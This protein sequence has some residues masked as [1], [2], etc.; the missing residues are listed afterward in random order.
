MSATQKVITQEGVL[1]IQE[2]V[3]STQ[4]GVPSTQEGVPSTQDKSWKKLL[5]KNGSGKSLVQQSNVAENK[6]APVVEDKIKESG[7]NETSP[8]E[9]TAIKSSNN[10]TDSDT[11]KQP[12]NGHQGHRRKSASRKR[13]QISVYGIVKDIPPA[14]LTGDDLLGALKK[15]PKNSDTLNALLNSHKITVNTVVG[16]YDKKTDDLYRK[17]S[18]CCYLKRSTDGKWESKGDH[19]KNSR[20]DKQVAESDAPRIRSARSRS[21]SRS[22]EYKT[23]EAFLDD[24]APQFERTLNFAPPSSDEHYGSITTIYVSGK[25]PSNI[26][27]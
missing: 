16:L 18:F 17:G 2:G 7:K 9:E 3:P 23:F 10:G 20:L 19:L 25:K 5:R 14:K 21:R 11:T 4:E 6:E 13:D 27:A 24:F 22:N 1:S 8:P 12:R 15:A 26:V